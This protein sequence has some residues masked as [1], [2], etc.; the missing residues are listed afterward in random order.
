MSPTRIATL[1]GF[2]ALA[3][4]LPGVAL[5]AKA[6]LAGRRG[7]P[8]L[9]LYFDLWKLLRKGTVVSRLG[10]GLLPHL[11][12]LILAATVAAALPVPLGPAGGALRFPGDFFAF[13]GL[14]ALGRYSVVLAGLESGSSFEGM[15]AS[16]E[17]TIAAF[18]EPAL[19]L[20][21][22]C[23]AL[24][25]GARDLSGMFAPAG[26]A[27]WAGHGPA[28][29]LIAVSLFVLMLA[30]TAQVPVDDPTT[31][32]ELTMIHEVMI[33]DLGGPDLAYVL[34]AAALKLGL[35]AVLIAALLAPPG[36]G[37][38]WAPIGALAVAA[39]VGVV[40]G[41]AVRLRLDRLPQFLTAAIVLASLGLALTLR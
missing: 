26:T 6:V 7:A 8:V 3:P 10:T 1:L 31:H 32:L 41:L 5:R 21:V 17:V 12:A 38:W 40:A 39:L 34:Y 24:L 15:G 13:A 23:L 35:L 22:A 37:V 33:L 16:R 18:A 4:A 27:G 19:L 20:S 25:S 9:Q 36:A 11:P 28:V 14:L 29:I 30:E 2:L